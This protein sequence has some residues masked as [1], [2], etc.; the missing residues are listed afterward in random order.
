MDHMSPPA[1]TRTRARIQDISAI[2]HRY[3]RVALVLQG[4]GALGAYQAGVYQALTDAN[5]SLNWISVV[6]SAQSTLR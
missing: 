4:G 5:C 6:S 1:E 2:S 3:D